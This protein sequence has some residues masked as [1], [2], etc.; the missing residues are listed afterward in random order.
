MLQNQVIR[1]LSVNLM[2]SLVLIFCFLLH[3]ASKSDNVMRVFIFHEEYLFQ[4]G[5]FTLMTEGDVKWMPISKTF[6]NQKIRV[7][8]FI[9][10]PLLFLLQQ[11]VIFKYP[12]I[13][14]AFFVI[15]F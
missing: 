3:K 5:T 6:V 4:T 11:N 9:L 1:G 13:F 8:N 14:S 15:V 7:I 12:Y 10:I 2:I